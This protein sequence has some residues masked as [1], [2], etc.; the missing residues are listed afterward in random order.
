MSQRSRR[1]VFGAIVILI[2]TMAWAPAVVAAPPTQKVCASRTN[3]N[4]KKLLECVTLE[5][6]REHQAAL[7]EIADDNGGTRAAGTPG[8]EDSVDYVVERMTAAGYNVTLNSFPF[9]FVPPSS[10]RQ[11]TPVAATYETGAFTSSGSGDITATV[12][13]IDINLTP[14]RA[15]TSG[16]DGAFTEAFVGAPLTPDPAGVDDFAG[17]P[18]G[19]IALIQRGGC[20]FALKAYNAQAAGAE[21]R[22]HFQPGRHAA[23][24]SPH[25]GQ[26]HGSAAGAVRAH[27]PRRRRVVR[28]RRG[29]RRSR[30][31]RAHQ[32]PTGAEHHDR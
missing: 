24:R 22:H 9:V 10:L 15:N 3:D 29:P 14:P 8:Y 6:V 1:V 21:R 11:L 19:A 16:C 12:V 13:A 27:H 7:Q 20:S 28:Q 25:R 5:G 30:L 31:D 18:A 17:F 23:A 32:R 2:A 4:L 26:R